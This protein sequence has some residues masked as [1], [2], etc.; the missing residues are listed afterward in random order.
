MKIRGVTVGTPLKPEK[1]I[2]K[3]TDL[4]EEQKAQARENI[5]AAKIDDSKIGN[6]G[7]SSKN[8]VDKLCP[9]FTESGAVVTCNPVEGYPLSVVSK[10]DPV[11]QSDGTFKGQSAVKLFRASKNLFNETAKKY[12]GVS[13]KSYSNGEIIVTNNSAGTYLSANLKIP[14]GEALVG[15]MVTVKGEWSESGSNQGCLRLLWTDANSPSTA[16]SIT[17]TLTVKTSGKSASIVVKAKPAAAGELCLFLYSN[18]E[19][20]GAKGDTV[21]Y[22][23]I[24]LEIGDVATPYEPYRGEEFTIDLGQTVYGG[25][26]DWNS[27]VFTV[28]HGNDGEQLQEPVVIQLTPKEIK[29]LS[30]TNTL[31]GN[32]SNTEVTGKADPTA[33]IEKL[34]NAIIA[35]GGNV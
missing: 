29:A 15:K 6:D 16:I 19:G 27:G 9:G 14:N 32:T 10:I 4:T 18:Y 12:S 31:Y 30:G 28:T 2:I 26:L 24:Q 23:N 25:Y 11:E 22:R 8:T 13:S 5:D 35:L 20:T 21:T 33:I 34:T 7:W 1:S 3:A 17:N